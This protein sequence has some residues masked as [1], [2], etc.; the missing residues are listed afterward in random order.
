MRRRL[1]L[2]VAA[3][4]SLVLVA[5]LVPLALLV[6][7]SAADRAVSSAVVAAQAFAPTVAS[8][9]EAGLDIAVREANAD[10]QHP[11]T[12]FMP[13]GRVVGPP[14]ERSAA[15]DLA[16]TGRSIT[17]DAPGG[18]QILVAVSGLPGGTAVIRTFVSDAELTRGVGR[19]WLVLCGLGLGLLL[20]SMLVADQLA[21]S[22]VRPLTAVAEVSHRLAS[23]DLDA[24]AVAGGPAEVLAVG[25][26]LNLLAARTGE[27]LARE[28]E[29]AADLSHRLRTPLTALRV[30]TEALPDPADRMRITADVDALERTV[31]DII[32]AARQ[33]TYD[34]VAPS[35][36]AV[37]VVA[38]RIDFWSPL[39]DEEGRPFTA[40]LATG[41][42]PVRVSRDDLTACVDA[43]LGNV[44]AH[45]P[46]GTGFSVAL[47]P[48]RRGGAQ[49]VLADDGPGLPSRVVPQRGRSGQGSTGLGLDIARRTATSSG[50]ALTLGRNHR[51]GAEIAVTFGAPPQ[52]VAARG[53]HAGG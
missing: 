11:V 28:R 23:G 40:Q 26:G 49:L 16:A 1:V 45:T 36:D 31:D 48:L 42:I 19:A 47:T 18:R 8:A 29:T 33:P 10:N 13:D 38:E 22:V 2:L 27:L 14:A 7:S 30:D 15:I 4:T 35:C 50:G 9:D 46:E 25:A 39:A 51:G 20:V 41:P 53:A 43:L 37:E 32:R 44:F 12:V 24:R 17:A 21:R 6:R 5:F 34:G 52:V 3:T